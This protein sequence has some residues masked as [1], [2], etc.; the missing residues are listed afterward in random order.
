MRIRMPS[1]PA[2]KVAALIPALLAFAMHSA[3]GAAW[4]TNR[5]PSISIGGNTF[6]N[7][8][9]VEVTPVSVTIAH[10]RGLASFN[11]DK[12]L[13]VD[14]ERLGLIEKV[15]E[16]PATSGRPKQNL[17]T[18]FF[19]LSGSNAIRL[20]TQLESITPERA[21]KFLDELPPF[22]PTMLIGPLIAYFFFCLCSLQ[23]CRKAGKPSPLLVWIPIL[24]IL[25][26]YRAA[27][28][29]PL[30]FG[31]LIVQIC[32]EIA[33]LFF[34]PSEGV[35]PQMLLV[36][37]GILALLTIIQLFGFIL[38]SFRICTARG[39]SPVLGIF[40]LLPCTNIFALA[41]LAFSE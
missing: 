28:M 13:R 9:V 36:A 32:F 5:L 8:T 21:R 2:T 31:L 41:Y 7:V 23:I 27:R 38:W 1:Y 10:S 30:W 14:K 17:G 37:V 15:A 26:L 22:R 33:L 19:S 20:P 12:L 4:E 35:W 24:Q 29:R 6:S 11:P 18:N 39:K 16:P 40:L 25:P 3:F 34:M